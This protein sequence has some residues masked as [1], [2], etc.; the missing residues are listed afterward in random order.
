ME[1]DKFAEVP[2][3]AAATPDPFALRRDDLAAMRAAYRRESRGRRQWFGLGIGIGGL[4][5]AAVLITIGGH[6]GWPESLAPVFLGL[7]WGVMLTAYGVVYWRD[8]KMRLRW[9]LRCP[10]CQKPML[11]GDVSRAVSSRADM[12]IASGRCQHCGEEVLAP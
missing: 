9:Q 11:E 4:A 1:N 7:G 3:A 6:R 10:N 8:R 2:S 5:L 12:A